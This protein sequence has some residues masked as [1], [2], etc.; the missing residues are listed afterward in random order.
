MKNVILKKFLAIILLTLGVS[1]TFS[2]FLTTKIMTDTARENMELTLQ[3]IDY[4]LD[5]TG[6]LQEQIDVLKEMTLEKES[7]LTIM[8][9]DGI[10]EADTGG[11]T[12]EGL[13]NHFSREKIEPDPED[14][15]GAF[16][17][18]SKT[19]GA[20]MLY[21]SK[22]SSHSDYIIGLGHPF[23]G[24]YQ[25]SRILFPAVTVSFLLAII[26]SVFF[27]VGFSNSITKPLEEISEEILKLEHRN[28]EIEFGNYNYK[29]L[30][31]ITDATTRM[32]ETVNRTVERLE[33][34]KNIR[35]EFFSNVSHEL[36]TPITSIQGYAE[37]LEADMVP[38]EEMKKDFLKRIK[39]ETRNMTGLINDILMISKLETKQAEVR[40]TQIR[41]V[42]MLDE[43]LESLAPMAAELKVFMKT[44]CRPLMVVAD[45]KHIQ[46]LLTNLL[47]NAIKYNNPGGIVEVMITSVGEDFILAVKDNGMGIP[48]ESVTRVFER[49]YRV[50][51]GRSKK[52]GGT[53]LGL[54]IVKHIVQYYQ[55]GIDLKSEIDVGTEVTVR[56]PIRFDAI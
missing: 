32:S 23:V 53:G 9:R 42:P 19:M 27:S 26:V 36:K 43:V 46:Q 1:G 14:R 8:N 22:A 35:Q 41:I 4:S 44:D 20:A 52:M 28:P 17:G 49:F 48:K 38:N 51:K 47:G 5:Y 56:L 13:E 30:N 10:V 3:L 39:K 54:A 21:V 40:K 34:E 55:G 33:Q 37:L 16:Q 31:T 2:Y 24:E 45:P 11:E 50:D 18:S 12:P 15:T 7:R 25:Y 6:N 29:E